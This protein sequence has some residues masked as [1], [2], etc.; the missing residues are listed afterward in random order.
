M[1]YDSPTGPADA[2]FR[3]LVARAAQRHGHD[4]C[5]GC[6]RPFKSQEAMLIGRMRRGGVRVVGECC[7]DRLNTVIGGGIYVALPDWIRPIAAQHQEVVVGQPNSPWSRDDREWFARNRNRSHRLRAALPGEWP[8]GSP[9]SVVRQGA[10][11][12]RSRLPVTASKHLPQDAPE[13]LAWAMFDLVIEHRQR[14][15]N[16]IPIEEIAARIRRL[17]AGGR[18]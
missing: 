12:E 16:E 8:D 14:G 1:G 15:V 6:S 3:R 9:L 4:I 18:A 2:R 7:G 10:P 13:L 11:G 5:H 17:G